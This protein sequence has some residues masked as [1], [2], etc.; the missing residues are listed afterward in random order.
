MVRQD[1]AGKYMTE[2]GAQKAGFRAA[3]KE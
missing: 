3:E 1:Q 2:A